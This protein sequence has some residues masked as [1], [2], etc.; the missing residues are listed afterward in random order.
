MLEG[1]S[2]PAKTR[3]RIYHHEYLPGALQVGSNGDLQR[4]TQ[5]YVHSS[6]YDKLYHS[7]AIHHAS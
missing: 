6:Y 2:V 5:F 1:Q 7:H 3:S 4:R